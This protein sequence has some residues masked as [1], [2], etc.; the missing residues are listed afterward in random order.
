MQQLVVINLKDNVATATRELKKDQELR[1]E[2]GGEQ[3]VLTMKED[4]RFGHKVA[5]MD[6]V[7][8]Q[9]IIKYGE[10]MGTATADVFKGEH[11]HV[12]NVVSQRGRGDLAT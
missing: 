1:V 11:I 9:D 8:G 6:L 7:K 2:I 3:V 12:H 5:I 4:I 10:V